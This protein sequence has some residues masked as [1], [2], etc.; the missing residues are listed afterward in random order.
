M[1]MTR[2]R[3]PSTA[4]RRMA[5]QSAQQDRQR[6]LCTLQYRSVEDLDKVLRDAAADEE[7]RRQA[8]TDAES[9]QLHVQFMR[10]HGLPR[11][12]VT[13]LSTGG[14]FVSGVDRHR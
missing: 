6:L 10:A 9:F 5:S 1:T 12:E 11:G 8:R 13:T 3:L 2:E 7:R 4:S 14:V